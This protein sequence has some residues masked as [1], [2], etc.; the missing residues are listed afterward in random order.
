VTILKD[1]TDARNRLGRLCLE[2]DELE[3]LEYD[4]PALTQWKLTASTILE[5]RFGSEHQLCTRFG[6]LTFEKTLFAMWVTRDGRSTPLPSRHEHNE[7]YRADL[8]T[9]QGILRAALDLWNIVQAT[10]EPSPTPLV[11][12]NITNNNTATA[13]SVATA[14][15][16]IEFPL[17]ELLDL[18]D[19]SQ[20]LTADVKEQAKEHL[21]DLDG[22][23]RKPRPRW[24]KVKPAVKFL[25]DA[26]KEI[27]IK[28][29]PAVVAKMATGQ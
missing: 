12:N 13:D 20:D 27:A 2:I 17:E 1:T 19:G 4:N 28:T 8:A 21:E 6:N 10:E 3:K 25:L 9:A 16:L 24:E 7:R 18:V 22:E 26:G 11:Q 15:A 23:L 5:S 29:L 14:N